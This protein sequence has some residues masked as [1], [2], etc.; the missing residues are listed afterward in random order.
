MSSFGQIFAN[1][2]D[3]IDLST[4]ASARQVRLHFLAHAITRLE[5]GF[6]A[7]PKSI[8]DAVLDPILTP[9]DSWL[10]R[11]SHLHRQSVLTLPVASCF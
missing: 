3:N 1:T 10:V 7:L 6:K 2:I 9:L 8:E 5:E 4:P 11:F